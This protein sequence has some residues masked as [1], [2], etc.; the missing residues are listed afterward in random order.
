MFVIEKALFR[1]GQEMRVIRM[2][3]LRSKRL[4]SWHAVE[5]H[6]IVTAMGGGRNMLLKRVG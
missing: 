5:V 1:I 3:I 4:H 6:V 2:I